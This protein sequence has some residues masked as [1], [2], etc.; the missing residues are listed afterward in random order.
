M[1]HTSYPPKSK[2]SSAPRTMRSRP[3]L[4]WQLST[5]SRISKRRLGWLHTEIQRPVS[6]QK[7]SQSLS[8]ALVFCVQRYSFLVSKHS[9]RMRYSLIL[10][11]LVSLMQTVDENRSIP[12]FFAI[13][14]MQRGIRERNRFLPLLFAKPPVSI[15]CARQRRRRH[16][17]NRTAFAPFFCKSCTFLASSFVI[18]T[19]DIFSNC[20]CEK[21]NTAICVSN[22]LL[23]LVIFSRMRMLNNLLRRCFRVYDTGSL[24]MPIVK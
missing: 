24:M 16:S 6:S 7:D 19:E 5:S 22:G 9:S 10:S 1:W 15:P 4:I 17:D 14:L 2:P 21:G 3:I 13:C 11:S 20:L 23:G 12:E 8:A 18:R